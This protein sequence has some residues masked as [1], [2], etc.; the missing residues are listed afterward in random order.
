MPDVVD[1]RAESRLEIVEDGGTAVL[2]YRI[3]GKRFSLIHTGVPKEFE[4]KGFGSALVKAAI[5]K[6]RDEDL[7]VLP[8]CPYARA[9]IEKHPEAVEGIEVGAIG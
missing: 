3:V 6:A 5:Q 4:G 7:V 8:Y 9:W 1:N 2:E